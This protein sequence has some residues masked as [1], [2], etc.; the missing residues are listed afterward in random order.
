VVPGGGVGVGSRRLVLG[1]SMLGGPLGALLQDLDM[2]KTHWP[3][4]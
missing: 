3:E 4:T 1:E 2:V